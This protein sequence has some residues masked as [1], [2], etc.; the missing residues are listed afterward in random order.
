MNTNLDWYTAYNAESKTEPVPSARNYGKGFPK[1]IADGI[2]VSLASD[3]LKGRQYILV[4]EWGPYNFQS[5]SIWL[6]E[7]NKK[8]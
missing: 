7:I 5:P 2:E 1:K 6:R 3:Q 8:L 4:D